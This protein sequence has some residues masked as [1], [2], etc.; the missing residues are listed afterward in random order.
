MGLKIKINCLLGLL[1]LVGGL[2]SCKSKK[3]K[4]DLIIKNATIWTGNEKQMI[5]Q[6]MAIA[7]D[8]II[9]VGTNEEMQQFKIEGTKVL[10][11]KG[12]FITPGFIDCH[13]HL[14]SGGN[15]LLG[16]QLIDANTPAEFTKRIAAF[17]KTIEPGEWIVEGNWD[18]TLWGGELPKKEWIDADTKEIP[19]VVHRMDWH[20]LLANSKALEMAGINKNTPDVSGGEIVRYK[21]G[22]PTGILKDNAMKLVLEKMPPLTDEQKGKVFKAAMNYFLSNGVTSVHD[23]DGLKKNYESYSAAN[24]LRNTG[25]LSIRIYAARP[26]TEWDKQDSTNGKNDKWLKTGLVKGFVDGSLGSHTAAFRDAYTDKAGDKGFFINTKDDLYKWISNADKKNLHVTV[27]AI[28]DSAIHALLDI[29]ERIIQ[30]NGIKDRRLRIEHVQ[31]LLPEDIRRFAQLGVIASMQPYHAIDD[32]RWAEKV[33]GTERIK[34]TY[35]FKSLLDAKATVVFGSDWAVA[36]AAPL[37]GIYAAVTRRTLDGKNPD[38]WVPEQKISVEQALIS[39]TRNAAFASFDEKIKGTLEV[40]K[41]ADFVILNSDITKIN[42]IEIN[43]VKVLQ[44]Y[45]GGK[46]MFDI[47]GVSP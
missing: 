42:P 33:I 29:Y 38:G 18:H 25:E 36:P 6:S 8:S 27:H 20:M 32:G 40:G 9:G 14:M 3:L 41:L 47:S 15:G 11:A 45:V 5:A 17:A 1:I 34:T 12:G 22:T 30:E 13:V 4:A 46:K 19:V 24:T 10:D 2:L 23:V 21:D 7:G 16:V 26:L 35:A 44:T 31:H 37:Q 43:K 39:Y 28:G